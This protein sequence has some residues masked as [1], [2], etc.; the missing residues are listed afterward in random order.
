M[1]MTWG[2]CPKCGKL[3]VYVR[4]YTM[5]SGVLP[6]S[7]IGWTTVNQ[8]ICA[9]CGFTEM[10]VTDA[11]K[12]RALHK[13]KSWTHVQPPAPDETQQLPPPADPDQTQRLR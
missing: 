4:V 8:Y 6:I 7:G 3:D 12:L 2:Q 10:Y 9:G 11:A 13:S 1:A 5:G